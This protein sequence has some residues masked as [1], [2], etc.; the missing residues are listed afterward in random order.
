M[1]KCNTCT[2]KYCNHEKEVI[3]CVYEDEDLFNSPTQFTD[4]CFGYLDENH[5]LNM[6]NLYKQCIEL[7]SKKQYDKL[8]SAKE[9]LLKL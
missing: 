3:G 8:L 6:I 2:W 5:E 7:L 1:S 4:K 9:Y